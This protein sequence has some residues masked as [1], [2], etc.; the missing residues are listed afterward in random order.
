[1]SP[2]DPERGAEV[3]DGLKDLGVKGRSKMDKT[4]LAKA[5]ARKQD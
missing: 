3:A 4:E 2:V 5:I 1:M